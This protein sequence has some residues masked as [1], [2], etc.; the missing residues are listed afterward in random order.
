MRYLLIA[1][2][3]A[4]CA[5]PEQRADKMVARYGPICDR[6]GYNRTSD[7]WRDCVVKLDLEPNR[8]QQ[9]RVQ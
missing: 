1:V 7:A 4:G 9:V 3:L 2:L 8:V 6:L 5:T